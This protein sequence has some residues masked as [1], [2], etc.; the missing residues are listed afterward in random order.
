MSG[1]SA[2]RGEQAFL[3]MGIMGFSGSGK[4]FTASQIAVGLH[5]HCTQLGIMKGDDPVFFLDTETGADWV[6]KMFK[7]R[8]IPLYVDKTRSFLRLVPA[9]KEVAD[10]K[11]ILII[12]S[13]THFWRE[14]TESFARKKGR[15]SLVFSDW[16]W[17]KAQWGTFT[18]AFVN[19]T[20]HII[21]CGRAGFEYDFFEAEDGKRELEKTGIKMKAEGE[22]GYE[23]SILVLMERRQPMESGTLKEA[24]HTARVLKDRGN[25]IH[26]KEFKNPTFQDF[27]PH[28][29]CLNLGGEH[30]GVN[31]A[32]TSEALVPPS[33]PSWKKEEEEKEVVLDEIQCHLMK[34]YPGTKQS[35]KTAKADLLEAHFGTRSWER[36]VED[37]RV[38]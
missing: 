14:L 21:M 5:Q 30:V 19:S 11:G 26:G 8:G 12:D 33:S 34:Q 31:T 37:A 29:Q 27:L 16:A 24:Y 28:I 17:L 3:K 22:T 9:L 35:D 2:V 6:D 13:V 25:V 10:R 23:P 15:T 4:T 18:D 1:F 38:E 32:E 36:A 7:E 20:C